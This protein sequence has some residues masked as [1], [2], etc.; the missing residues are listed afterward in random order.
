MMRRDVSYYDLI[1][2]IEE[3]GFQ[4]IDFLYYAKKT[5]LGSSYLVHIYDEGLVMKMLSDPEIVKAVH[6]YVSKE[7]ADDHIAPPSKQIDVAP[8]NHPNESVLLQDGGVSAEGAGQLTM[9]GPQRP[10]RRSKRLNVIQ[11]TDQRD[12]EDGDCNNGEQF[13]QGHE[14]QALVDEEGQVHNQVDKEVRKRKRTSL[15]IVWNMPKGQRIVV[16][17]NEDSQPIGDEGAILGKF[18]GT[19]ARNGGFCPLN[20]NDWRHVKK[21]S[22]EETILQ[23]VQTKFVYPRSCEKWILKSIGRD[24]R[25]FKSSLKDAFFKPAIEKNPNIKR[26]ALYKLCP[27]DVDN[28]QWRGLVKYWKSKKGRALPE[29]NIISRSLVKDSHNDGTKSYACWG[30]DMRQ[31]DPEKKRPHRSKVY[32]ATHKKKDD[33]DA[34]NKDRNKRL[35]RLENLITEQPELAQNL[36]GRV[37]WEGDALQEVL[38][39]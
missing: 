38:G 10:P 37:A 23:C 32:L 16:K 14:S 33:A 4:A 1:L 39:K 31:A 34:K 6:L 5:R 27:E 7:K 20:I 24:W 12:D 26:K 25:K 35:D 11:V 13:P 19:I 15:P 28:D 9:Q 21:N 22:G 3:V 8:S 36:N 2:M 17:C 18:L 29:K 30:E